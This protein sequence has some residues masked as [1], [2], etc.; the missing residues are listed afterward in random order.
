MK[1]ITQLKNLQ[2][3][4]LTAHEAKV[5]LLLQTEVLL[6]PLELSR[7]CDIPRASI[8]VA[9]DTLKKRGLA[10]HA[11]VNKKNKWKRANAK[12]L[13]DV[14]YDT[15]KAVLGFVDGKEEVSGATDGVVTI[16]RGKA[17]V[18]KV[19][20]GM[21]SNRKH[22]RFLCYTAFSDLIDKGWLTIF[23][24]EEINEF[25]RIVKK[26][27]IISELVAP[28]HW[29]EDHY[30]AMGDTWAK[31]YEGRASSAVYLSKR[32]FDHSA[33]IFAF[34]DAMYLLALN[35]K[36][37]IEIRHS[38]IQKMILAMYGF[39]KERGDV[40]DVNRRLRELM[41]KG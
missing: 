13:G 18:K 31:D 10:H 23:T 22:E 35:D 29:I 9:L 12:E 32:Y 8:Y 20:F 14:L 28:E 2:L 36:M 15:K 33:Q 34:K 16:H 38:D 1:P 3:L 25:N 21:I 6:T 27:G 37:I 30:N 5:F 26:N 17:A 11:V 40:V 41:G 39:M 4:N 7:L 19:V 24:P